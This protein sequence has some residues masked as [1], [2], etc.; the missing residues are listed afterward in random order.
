MAENSLN[1][2]VR[3]ELDRQIKEK[4]KREEDYN[5]ELH[6][7][8]VEQLI[9]SDFQP[10]EHEAHAY[11]MDNLFD[12]DYCTTEDRVSRISGY[13]QDQL[14]SLD[15]D[16]IEEQVKKV[17]DEVNAPREEELVWKKGRPTVEGWYLWKKSKTVKDPGLFFCYYYE[18]EE[19]MPP[20]T[21]EPGGYLW[22]KGRS[23][24]WPKGGWWAGPILTPFTILTPMEHVVKK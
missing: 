24:V 13:F 21:R 1:K 20:E 22:S 12:D 23:L 2:A 6:D 9:D 5:Q 7:L 11:V 18:R 3:K 15:W 14:E 10:R 8:V 4:I 16:K 17:K 19:A